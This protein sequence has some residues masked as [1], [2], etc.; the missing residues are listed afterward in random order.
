MKN[1]AGVHNSKWS[2]FLQRKLIYISVK[3]FDT[4]N[5]NDHF[6]KFISFDTT[7]N[8]LKLLFTCYP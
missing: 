2:I 7:N 3:H 5:T 8:V 4:N 1:K 6:E